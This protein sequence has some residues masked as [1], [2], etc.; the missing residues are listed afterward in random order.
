MS[1]NTY[2]AAHA[3]GN[4]IHVT[5]TVTEQSAYRMTPHRWQVLAM[6]GRTG[7]CRNLWGT[8]GRTLGWLGRAKLAEFTRDGNGYRI[9]DAGRGALRQGPMEYRT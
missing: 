3:T 7:E 6:L 8:T 9:T 1:I 4:T 2:T 5:Y